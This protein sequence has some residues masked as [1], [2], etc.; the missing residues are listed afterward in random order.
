MG[1]MVWCVIG[2]VALRHLPAAEPSARLDPPR[3][4]LL[5]FL[6]LI[7]GPIVN[8][9]EA[10]LARDPSVSG[11]QCSGGANTATQPALRLAFAL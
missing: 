11:R 2:L 4:A 1:G 3:A 5:A 7:N 10:N 8:S 6:F 9:R